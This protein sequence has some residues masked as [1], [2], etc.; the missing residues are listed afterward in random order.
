MDV[1]RLKAIPLFESF[2]EDDLRKIAPFAEENSVGAGETLVREG[3]YS[4]DLMVIE[5][6]NAEVR[7]G[8]QKL[9]ELGPGDF[10]GEMGVL[11]RERRNADVVADTPM[12]LIS[13]KTYDVKR[14]E[15][16]LPEAVEKLRDAV[17]QRRA[18]D[19]G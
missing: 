11:A 3:D 8:D 10:F 6:G 14:M 4:Y 16:N 2:S 13:F 5:E 7:Q 9:A 12:R 19:S 18:A 1:G 15:R 17:A